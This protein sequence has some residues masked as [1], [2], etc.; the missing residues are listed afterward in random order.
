MSRHNKNETQNTQEKRRKNANNATNA[1]N[2][3]KR[4]EKREEN[5]KKMVESA[6]SRWSWRQCSHGQDNFVNYLHEKKRA[7]ISVD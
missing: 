4:R 3:R 5:A 6:T 7:T 2:S 1:K